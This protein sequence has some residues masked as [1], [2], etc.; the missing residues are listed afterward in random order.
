[1]RTLAVTREVTR[2]WI[3]V[4]RRG[5]RTVIQR[6]KGQ[7]IGFILGFAILAL[8]VRLGVVTKNGV[9]GSW[10]AF[11][12]P[13]AALL[14][15][16][17]VLCVL[18]AVWRKHEEQR[19][20]ITGLV[21]KFEAE[22][23]EHKAD[24]QSLKQEL[25]REINHRLS[26]HKAGQVDA[27]ANEAQSLYND[28]DQMLSVAGIPGKAHAALERPLAEV[29]LEDQGSRGF[30]VEVWRFQK[31]LSA[32]RHRCANLGVSVESRILLGKAT[33]TSKSDEVLEMLKQ[34]HGLL[35][36]YSNEVTSYCRA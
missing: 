20:E 17:F 34:H 3:D 23:A 19:L 36:K 28:L 29:I 10:W 8:Q 11:L 15:I 32:H 7:A 16:V 31:Q 27:L 25:T 24:I 6:S 5:A 18:H 22:R 2:Y 26:W 21:N 1:M 35:L 33:E 13:Y 9:A 30:P 14:F 12:L 4:L